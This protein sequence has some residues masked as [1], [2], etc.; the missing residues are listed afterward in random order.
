MKRVGRIRAGRVALGWIVLGA[1]L[2][3]SGLR[4][5]EEQPKSPTGNSKAKTIPAS[6]ADSTASRDTVPQAPA[7][8]VLVFEPTSAKTR[9]LSLRDVL[10]LHVTHVGGGMQWTCGT[11]TMEADSAIKYDRERRVDLFGNVRY[12]DSIRTL[13]ADSLTYDEIGDLIVADGDVHLTRLESGSTLSGPRV[14]FLRAVSG[15]DERTIARQRPH[16][17]LYDKEHKDHPP[18]EVDADK[19]VFAGE[20]AAHA[21]GEVEIHRPDLEAVADSAFFDLKGGTGLLFGSPRVK[22]E[23]FELSGDT[24]RIR[25]E[26]GALRQVYALG[27]GEALGES[28]EV[29]AENISVEVKEE[30]VDGVWAYGPG[31]SLAISDPYRLYGDSLRFVMREGQI[32]TVIAVGGAS[33]VEDSTGLNA[34]EA[35]VAEAGEPVPEVTSPADT[36]VAE[37]GEPV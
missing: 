18:F 17:T 24:I 4:A 1:S 31:R 14:E 13:E 29:R 21:W 36:A 22:G 12:R 20:E 35:A 10:G 9:S 25:F 19:A 6:V 8:C 2:P 7:K 15:K 34:L 30:V 11:A 26:E 23:S 16:M 32:D 37:A 28:Y 33:A 27:H 3:V 5:Q